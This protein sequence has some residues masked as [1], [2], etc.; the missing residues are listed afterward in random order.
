MESFVPPPIPHITMKCA[1]KAQ[2]QIFGIFEF[3]TLVDIPEILGWSD[4]WH[5]LTSGLDV[6]FSLIFISPPR[7]AN[8]SG[9]QKYDQK[10]MCCHFCV[11][12]WD[13][14]GY[15][16]YSTLALN[17]LIISSCYLVTYFVL[18][19]V[20]LLSVFL[21][22]LRSLDSPHR[23]WC[24]YFTDVHQPWQRLGSLRYFFTVHLSLWSRIMDVKPEFSQDVR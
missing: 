3:C 1:S 22:F 14:Q 20:D 23:M 10:S 7:N 19:V 8:W 13:F 11:Y 18:K 21:H 24:C 9:D 15:Q 17:L 2:Q 4:F 12:I 5:F 6:S 16:G